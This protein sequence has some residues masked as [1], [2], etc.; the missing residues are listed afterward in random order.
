VDTTA[1]TSAPIVDV[2]ALAQ[3]VTAATELVKALV[4]TGQLTAEALGLPA[5][6]PVADVRSRDLVPGER[7]LVRD[8][9]AKTLDGLSE[10][11]ART[12][13]S[14]LRF[15]DQG[16][17][18][19]APPEERLFA[20]FGDRYFD[21]VLPSELESALEM[22]KARALMTA[23]WRA[24]RREVAGRTVRDSDAG[25]AGYNAVGAWR[26]M[27]KVAVKDRHI[28]KGYDPS[29]EVTK[30]KRSDG[31]RPALEQEQFDELW[32]VVTG[33]GDDPEL[34]ELLVETI[35]IA[36]ARV[37]G[38]LNLT[39][40]GVDLDDCTLL[41]DEKFGK[42]VA[43]PVPDWFAAKV[44]A[45]AVARGA[46]RRD[47]KV[48]VYRKSSRRQGAAITDRRFD[49]LF[50]D[51]VQ[52]MLPWADKQQ[53]TAHTLRHHAISVVERRFSKAVSLAFARHEPEDVNDKYSRASKEEVAQAVVALYGGAHPWVK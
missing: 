47:D 35:L 29:Q 25:G 12:Y 9:V 6:P 13:G 31:L 28:A 7:I 19:S 21:E 18:A 32:Q 8:L 20:G 16:W 4:A 49:N 43:Q 10:G 23:H 53:V 50:T 37:E 45:F 40:G 2:L 44:H 51:R 38:L 17:P 14:Y 46:K 1:T 5:A 24:Q 3:Q 48:F 15:I 11:S 34:D 27:G 42:K 39:L 30:P 36:G 41:L 26:R 52:A 22:V 33:T